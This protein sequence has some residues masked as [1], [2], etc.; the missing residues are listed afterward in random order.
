YAGLIEPRRLRL[1]SLRVASEAW[2]VGWRPLRVAVL[3]DFHTAWP[4]VTARRLRRVVER[5]I[6]VAPE[7]ILLPGDFVSSRTMGVIDLP[8]ELTAQALAP[9]AAAAPTYAVL[10]NHDHH[11][12]GRRVAG[13]LAEVGITS[14]YNRA[15]RL[16]LDER[17][18]WLA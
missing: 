2:P 10:G 3:S 15:E 13:A 9:L 6:A 16:R 7:L 18:L 12:G 1:S 11:V 8:I 5:T 4:H 14:L 17:D